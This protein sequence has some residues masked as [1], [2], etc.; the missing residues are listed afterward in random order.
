MKKTT[1]FAT[2]ILSGLLFTS[3]GTA[4]QDPDSQGNNYI[5]SC[6]SDCSS[7]DFYQP[8][9]QENDS[10]NWN[11]GKKVQSDSKIC[12]DKIQEKK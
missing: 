9:S 1:L 11:F 4:S 2:A 10:Q 12:R 6:E 5:G 8:S 7:F 3:Q